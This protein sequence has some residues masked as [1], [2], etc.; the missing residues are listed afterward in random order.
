[1][2]F[3]RRWFG[4]RDAA[5]SSPPGARPAPTPL[6]PPPLPRPTVLDPEPRLV[7]TIVEGP[8]GTS[9]F[10]E[11]AFDPATGT[12]ELRYAHREDLPAWMD[13]V[14][15]PL[16][17]GKGIPTH[18]YVTLR[19]MKQLGIGIGQARAFRL[20]AIHEVA[21]IVHLDWLTA[22]HPGVPLGELARQTH[23]FAYAETPIIQSGHRI[24]SAHVD[25]SRA[26]RRPIGD[27]MT[28]DERMA[29]DPAALRTTHDAV[30][31]RHQRTRDDV[32]LIG[33]DLYLAVEPQP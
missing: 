26:T 23:S 16:V 22:R 29:A 24:V 13:G 15:V 33:Y 12:V 31:A 4:K 7:T 11:R 25:T 14:P 1:M 27:L 30:L 20:R 8:G 3:W 9:G 19:A 17:P 18:T 6:Q 5:S 21:S 2:T 32:M 10:F 28:H